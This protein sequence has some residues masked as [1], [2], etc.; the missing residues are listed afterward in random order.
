MNQ[1]PNMS[2]IKAVSFDADMTLW[3]FE[4]VMRHS[5]RF[6]LEELR[7]CLP[8]E[9]TSALSIDKMIEIRNEVA[10]ELQGKITNLEQIRFHAFARTVEYVGRQDDDLAASL[11]S[12][13]LKHRFEDVELYPDVLPTL[14]MLR[15]HF[16]LGLVSNGNSY[17]EWCG[18]KERFAFVIFSQDIGYAKPDRPIFEAACREAKCSPKELVHVGDSLE[19][20]VAGA[21]AVGAVSVW[22]NRNR[23]VNDTDARPDFE[24]WSLEQLGR[25]LNVEKRVSN[26][27]YPGDSP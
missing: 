18:L 8:S 19:N 4:K 9:Q 10:N 15:T 25:I 6:A 27:P 20:D 2:H 13:Y 5:L 16:R 1:Q 17:P 23:N 26:K 22:L 11:N 12:I 21:N 7:R 14:D 3:D 24:I